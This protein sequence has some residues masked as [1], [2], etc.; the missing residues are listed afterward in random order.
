MVGD[1]VLK[2]PL[3]HHADKLGLQERILFV[4]SLTAQDISELLRI[5]DLFLLSS[6]YEGMP[7]CVLEAL[8]CGLPVATTDVGEVGRVVFEGINGE[9]TNDRSPESLSA[10]IVSCLD[11][12][13]QYS[14]IPC[15]NA[16]SEYVP[17]RVL[18][19]VYENYRRLA[20]NLSAV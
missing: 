18:E 17:S 3:K 8:G 19:P 5:A 14:G 4:G 11:K 9:I 13:P 2:N 12:L 16:V 20:G 6:A 10:T 1:G 15:T 7:I